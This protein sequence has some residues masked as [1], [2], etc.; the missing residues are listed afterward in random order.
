MIHVIVYVQ[1]AYLSLLPRHRYTVQTHHLQLLRSVCALSYGTK[2][3][4]SHHCNLL[5][6][7]NRA[8]ELSQVYIWTMHCLTVARPKQ[9]HWSFGW[10]KILHAVHILFF[11][12]RSIALWCK[13]VKPILSKFRSKVCTPCIWKTFCC[14]CFGYNVSSSVGMFK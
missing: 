13:I 2:S 9:I 1:Y 12:C 7:M 6:A 5:P 8:N 4:Q 14:D 11:Q 3:V 10:E